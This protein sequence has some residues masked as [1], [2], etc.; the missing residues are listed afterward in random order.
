MVG[1]ETFEGAFSSTTGVGCVEAIVLDVEGGGGGCP[2]E[3]QADNNI[4]RFNAGVTAENAL[5]NRFSWIK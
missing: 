4:Y 2:Q 3:R 5:A 1:A